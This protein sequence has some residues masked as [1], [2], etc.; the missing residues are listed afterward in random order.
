VAVLLARITHRS[1]ADLALVP[2][3]PGWVQVKSVAL[4]R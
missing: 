4:M 2:G 3:K 1:A